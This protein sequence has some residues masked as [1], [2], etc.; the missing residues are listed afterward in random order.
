MEGIKNKEIIK[1]PQK[2]SNG[3]AEPESAKSQSKKLLTLVN[4]VTVQKK[5]KDGVEMKSP[6]YSI[7]GHLDGNETSFKTFDKGLADL[8]ASEAGTGV[9]VAIEY[10]TDKYGHKALTVEIPSRERTPGE[11]G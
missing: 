8:A 11:D 9:M 6:L 7:L 3:Q 2:K 10:E 5:N 4:K 1:E